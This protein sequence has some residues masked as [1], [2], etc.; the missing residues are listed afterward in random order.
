MIFFK[1]FIGIGAITTIFGGEVFADDDVAALR[2]ADAN[3]N[4]R[5]LQRDPGNNRQ[6]LPVLQVSTYQMIGLICALWRHRRCRRPRSCLL[7]TILFI[8]YTHQKIS[9]SS[10][11]LPQAKWCI[12]P[13]SSR[14]CIV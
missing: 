7:Y 4:G 14:L 12:Q 13:Q 9:H 2:V 6:E 8:Q 3:S 5:Q 10:L 1:L 11:S